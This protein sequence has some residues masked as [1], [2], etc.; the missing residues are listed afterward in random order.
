MLA[1]L[2]ENPDLSRPLS[3]LLPRM[4]FIVTGV[5]YD[6]TRKLVTVN[7]N[8]K[9]ND[10]SAAP[11]SQ[12]NAVPYNIS[13]ELNVMT[14]VIEDGTMIV[15]QILPYFTPDWS[16]TIDVIPEMG[17]LIDVPVILKSVTYDDA[18]EG[19][20]TE[21]RTVVWTLAFDM[22]VHFYGPVKESKIIKIANTNFFA[23]DFSN[24]AEFDLNVNIKPGM[25]AN[26]E[27][28]SNAS[29]S[30]PPTS[31]SAN[32]NYDYIITRS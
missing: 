31:I 28:T 27:P 8:I 7:K 22:Y 3:T 32:D 1:R 18:Y 9:R 10:A 11:R 2:R 21:R 26:G 29:L 30:V 16:V 23:G 25:M 4:S 5:T 20:Y 19:D 24:T 14:K 15:E 13:F 12:Y 6:N 17:M